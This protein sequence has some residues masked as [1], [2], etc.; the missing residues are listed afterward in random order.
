MWASNKKKLLI[1]SILRDWHIPPLHL[2]ELKDK[3]CEVLDG[4][5][6]LSAIRDF[7]NNKFAI[8]GSIEPYSDV[9]ANLDN[10]RYR[11]LPRNVKR[12]VDQFALKIY[13]IRNYQNGEP[14]ELFHRLNQTVKLTSAETRNS[15]FGVVRND[16]SELVKYMEINEV[17]ASIL[18]FSNSRMSYND[19]LCRVAILL[20]KNS[21][22][23]HAQLMVFPKGVTTST[24]Y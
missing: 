16:I 1:D 10:L 8:D 14:N 9:I 13:K 4:Q 3:R 6:R 12:N 23:Y 11:D 24:F 18:G 7:I 19:M 22:K 21:L 17:D 15:I 20:E 2:V 5:Q